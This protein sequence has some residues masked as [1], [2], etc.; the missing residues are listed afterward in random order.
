VMRRYRVQLNVFRIHNIGSHNMRTFEMP[1]VGGI[2]LAPYS[3]EQTTFFEDGKE[4]FYYHDQEQMADI[5]ARLLAM[6][7]DET[8]CIRKN[9]R[10]RSVHSGYTY[11]HRAQTV[12]ETFQKMM[13]W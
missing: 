1:A 2:A 5:A 10:A 8:D 4:C 9:A 11:R 3:E 6:P 7:D 13:T 12:H